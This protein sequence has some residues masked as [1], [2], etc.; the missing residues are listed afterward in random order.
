MYQ[1]SEICILPFKLSIRLSCFKLWEEVIIVVLEYATDYLQF[2][3]FPPPGSPFSPSL[4]PPFVRSPLS[5][6]PSG[7]FRVSYFSLVTPCIVFVDISLS[8][9]FPSPSSPL[10]GLSSLLFSRIYQLGC[11][12]SLSL[13][14]SCYLQI[15][16]LFPVF[17]SITS[18]LP[19]SGYFPCVTSKPLRAFPYSTL[20]VV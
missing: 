9:S 1:S 17:T 18:V 7:P 11:S 3:P 5:C 13:S 15:Y 19:F 12:L 6:I 20:S 4:S 14:C 2:L 10:L 8:I 16:L